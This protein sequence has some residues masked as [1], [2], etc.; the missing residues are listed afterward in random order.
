M[1]VAAAR[2]RIGARLRA[3]R[4]AEAEAWERDRPAREARAQQQEEELASLQRQNRERDAEAAAERERAA[5]IEAERQ[6][7]ARA[8]AERQAAEATA[9]KHREDAQRAA[10]REVRERADAETLAR[11]QREDEAALPRDPCNRIE[12]R[13]QL[14][15]AVNAMDRARFG[16]RKLLDLTRGRTNSG[17]RTRFGRACSRR[18]GR[19]AS[20]GW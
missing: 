1:Q 18:S 8:Q 4:L 13:R 5:R 16:G 11:L 19:R 9:Q 3:V 7:G 14:M 15:E 17:S 10:D 12:V 6:A 2:A 20:V